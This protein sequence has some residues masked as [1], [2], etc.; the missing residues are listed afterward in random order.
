[1]AQEEAREQRSEIKREEFGA[2]EIRKQTELSVVAAAEQAK[3]L[4]QAKFIVAMKQRRNIDDVRCRILEACR[5]PRFAEKVRYAKPIGKGSIRG[6]SI[7]FAD[8]AARIMGNLDISKTTIYEDEMI[9]KISVTALDLE[10]NV[11]KSEEV[12]VKRTVERKHP[13]KGRPVLEWRMNTR[14]ERVAIVIATDDE[15]LVKEQALCAKARRNLELQ[16]IPQD[17]I[18]E[19][20]DESIKVVQNRDAK[21]PDAAKKRVVDAF[22]VNFGVRPSDLEAYLRHPIDKITPAEISDLR[23]VYES[24]IQGEATWAD[25]VSVSRE[26]GASDKAEESPAAK[27]VREKLAKKKS[28]INP[29]SAVYG[30]PTKREASDPAEPPSPIDPKDKKENGG[31]VAEPKEDPAEAPEDRGERIAMMLGPF[32][33]SSSMPGTYRMM[34]FG[35][36]MDQVQS[37]LIKVGFVMGI[38]KGFGPKMVKE[39]MSAGDV[40]N[41]LVY[42]FDFRDTDSG[43]LAYEADFLKVAVIDEASGEYLLGK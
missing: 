29:P 13:G 4:I 39:K 34:I 10:T 31:E 8:E 1:M 26:E 3:A 38:K 21:D 27:N 43:K 36:A 16:L 15:L 11:S 23:E 32:V 22:A 19:G 37:A 5:R 42:L 40:S 28:P 41:W 12:I 7:K 17:I 35:R 30:E 18:D 14:G 24:M 2:L 20:V 9:R 25:F 33:D 6:P